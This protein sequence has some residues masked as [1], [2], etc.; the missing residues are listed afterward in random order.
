MYIEK[1]LKN[2]FLDDDIVI[3]IMKLKAENK[4]IYDLLEKMN[5]Q[6]Y[7]VGK[8]YEKENPTQ[9]DIYV[10]ITFSQIHKSFQSFIILLER[11]LY[12]DSQIILR[13]MYDKIINTLYVLND[14]KNIE[15]LIQDNINEQL[16]TCRDIQKYE[17]YQYVSKEH[18]QQSL[19]ENLKCRKL[20]ENNK[21]IEKPSAKQIC[22]ELDIKEVYILYRL[23]SNY[24][25][26]AL[27]IVTNKIIESNGGILVNQG[28]DHGNFKHEIGLLIACMTLIIEPICNYLKSP[29]ILKELESIVIEL[30]K[31]LELDTNM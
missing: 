13:S 23:T 12:D 21:K 8:N 25:H 1:E 15:K 22:E 24:T 26:N 2:G 14:E 20:D 28:I 4:K 29:T 3:E 6:L 31:E 9:V 16:K 11:G 27:N 30:S 5:Q 10:R 18:V 17:L 7:E 19:E